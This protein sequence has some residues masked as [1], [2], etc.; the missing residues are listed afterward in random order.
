MYY[1]VDNEANFSYIREI[2]KRSGKS[3]LKSFVVFGVGQNNI[4]RGISQPKPPRT[5]AFVLFST[6]KD[7]A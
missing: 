1:T 7:K 4:S 2:N 3:S 6:L 5:Q